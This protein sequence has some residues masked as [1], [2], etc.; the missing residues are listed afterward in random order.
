VVKTSDLNLLK[1]NPR[2]KVKELEVKW[3]EIIR[4]N[5]EE[6]GNFDFNNYFQALKKYAS[7][8]AEYTIV[9]ACLLRMTVK[10]EV[11]TIETLKEY[12][13]IVDL[14]PDNFTQSMQVINAR[15]NNLFTKI[16]SKQKE[17]ENFLKGS[18]SKAKPITFAK[19]IM[20][21]SA[22]LGFT[23]GKDILLAEYNEAKKIIKERNGRDNKARFNKR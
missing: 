4:R 7:L 5:N 23:V 22:G 17:L 15:A 13:Y 16:V 1:L 3:E 11:K 19:A 6:N 9:K 21:L 14:N 8:V 12:G 18:D 20:H 2:G 10:A